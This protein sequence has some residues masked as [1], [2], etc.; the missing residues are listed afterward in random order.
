[1]RTNAI[2]KLA[3][4]TNWVGTGEFYAA[5]DQ[6]TSVTTTRGECNRHPDARSAGSLTPAMRRD[7]LGVPPGRNGSE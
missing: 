2:T 1:M 3:M 5:R 4:K 6:R 7:A